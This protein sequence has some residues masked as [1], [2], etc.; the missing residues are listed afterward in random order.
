MKADFETIIVGTGFGGLCMAH[1]LKQAGHDHILVLEKA[2][3]VGGTWRENTY[4]GAECDIPSA[5]YSYS[6]APNPAWDFKWAKQPQI[7][8]YLKD[9]ATTYDLRRHIRFGV[10]VTGAHYQPQDGL[11]RITTNQGDFTA[12]YFISAVGQLHHPSWPDIQ[13][14]TRF[15]GA[16]MHSAKWDHNVP[17]QGQNI[18]VIGSAASAIQFIPEL[19]KQARQLTV[20]QRSP[21]WVIDKGDRPYTAIEKSLARRFPV[22]LKLYRFGIWCLG[23]YGIYPIIK[24]AKIRAALARAKNRYDMKK[25]IKDPDMQK[26]LTPNYPIGAKRILFSDKYY[27]ALARENV[28]LE[29]QAIQEINNDG[30]V[31]SDGRQNSHD[32][33]VFATGFL[34]NPFLRGL[35]VTGAKGQTLQAHWA[36]GA[37]A[38]HGVMTAGFPNLFFLYGPN[39]N[40][41]HT[42]VVSQ[43]EQQA[44]YIIQLIQHT[45]ALATDEKK[46]PFVAVSAEAEDKYNQEMQARLNQLAWAK[47]DASWYKDGARIT[48][49]WPGNALEF[50]RRLKKPIFKDFLW[51]PPNA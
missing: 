28:S 10:A 47:I 51:M 7:F 43:L 17:L 45:R 41:G 44:D 14:R 29:T 31:L 20:Y 26:A 2:D 32:V 40:T 49:N 42:S 46:L 37:F 16:V 3:E 38:Y 4:P 21:N 13:G 5:L 39:T 24:G 25:H 35:H 18:G 8:S 48:N 23:E 22:I 36:E 1:K 6:F 30:V 15:Q 12:R 34:T 11:W 50:K 33:L 19:A 27:Q 9:F